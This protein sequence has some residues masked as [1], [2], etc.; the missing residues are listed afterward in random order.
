MGRREGNSR[1]DQAAT[2]NNATAQAYGHLVGELAEWRSVTSNDFRFSKSG[3]VKRIIVLNI[4]EIIV[5]NIP[6]DDS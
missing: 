3:C 2:A 6:L 4:I 1:R 5:V